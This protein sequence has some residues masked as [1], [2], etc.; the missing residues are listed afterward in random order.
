[1]DALFSGV[2]ASVRAAYDKPQPVSAAHVRGYVMTARNRLDADNVGDWLQKVPLQVLVWCE[3]TNAETRV[4]LLKTIAEKYE[5]E[6]A[7][8]VAEWS[9]D[10]FCSAVEATKHSAHG[11]V[12]S[13]LK[14]APLV[15]IGILGGEYKDEFKRA[16][17]THMP[18]PKLVFNA[19]IKHIGQP[20]GMRL[21]QL[22]AENM[23]CN[24][25]AGLH[26]RLSAL[27]TYVPLTLSDMW[28]VRPDG[29]REI[30]LVGRLLVTRFVETLAHGYD[31]YLGSAVS[32]RFFQPRDLLLLLSAQHGYTVC[33]QHTPTGQRLFDF[34]FNKNAGDDTFWDA[35]F[36]REEIFVRFVIQYSKLLDQRFDGPYVD[37]AAFFAFAFAAVDKRVVCTAAVRVLMHSYSGNPTTNSHGKFRRMISFGAYDSRF[38][39]LV[40]ATI[41]HMAPYCDAAVVDRYRSLPEP[42]CSALCKVWSC[43]K[44]PGLDISMDCSTE[45]HK[46]MLRMMLDYLDVF[47]DLQVPDEALDLLVAND[48]FWQNLSEVTTYS[49]NLDFNCGKPNASQFLA[50]ERHDAFVQTTMTMMSRRV[51]VCMNM[52]ED[53]IN[54]PYDA[55]LANLHHHHQPLVWLV[56]LNGNLMYT[57]SSR[58]DLDEPFEAVILVAA[59]LVCKSTRPQG[60][61]GDRPEPHHLVLPQVVKT[62][63][64]FLAVQ[65]TEEQR[66]RLMQPTARCRRWI[67]L[68]KGVCDRGFVDGQLKFSADRLHTPLPESIVAASVMLVLAFYPDTSYDVDL[69]PQI[70]M[71]TEMCLWTTYQRFFKKSATAPSS[72][73]T[74]VLQCIRLCK[75]PN[76]AKFTNIAVGLNRMWNIRFNPCLMFA[77]APL[78]F[79]HTPPSRFHR[80]TKSRFRALA[81]ALLLCNRRMDSSVPLIPSELCQQIIVD[82]LVQSRFSRAY[83]A[84]DTPTMY[85][86]CAKDGENWSRWSLAQNV[87][88]QMY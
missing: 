20:F 56:G 17:Q 66:T 25:G 28:F 54:L 29:F 74:S 3:Y 55:E 85:K 46:A 49:H 69:E 75:Q 84:S 65:F 7:T 11:V 87:Y 41:E 61:F 27:K 31:T 15:V 80:L 6:L 14:H 32:G 50:R 60:A 79:A 64:C 22:V 82:V 16:L 5:K 42:E 30:T 21:L 24:H 57:L 45:E 72:G 52:G 8:A 78:P 43:A 18:Q 12:L 26:K 9:V 4:P 19:T 2:T 44:V 76:I 68:L 88:Y 59:Y 10:A 35:S 38:K 23:F 77:M 40:L 47:E 83:F 58:M 63:F 51:M 37:R 1:M 73:I 36:F 33:D 13:F 86:E 70:G 81:R 53:P 34:I 48:D 62:I 67:E 39:A 71:F